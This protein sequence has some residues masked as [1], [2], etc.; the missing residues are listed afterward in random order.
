MAAGSIKY[1]QVEPYGDT[2]TN[3][4]RSRSTQAASP[5]P[6]S[7]PA[8]WCPGVLFVHG[9]GGSQEQYVARARKIAAL[10]CV[11]LTFD[12]RGHA[13]TRAAVRDRLARANLRDVLAAYDLLARPPACRPGAIAVVG[14]SYGGYLAAI[15][16]TMRP[17]RW[18]A[19]RAPALTWTPAG[20]CP[21]CSCTRT[22]TCRPTAASL[23]PV[24]ENRALQA[25]RDFKG[26]VL[27]I[28][29]EHD[30]IIPKAVLQSYREACK[31]ARSLTYRCVEGADHGL[32]RE[33][34]HRA[35][36]SMLVNWLKEMVFHARTGAVVPPS[37]DR[38]VQGEVPE[39]VEAE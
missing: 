3:P 16:T 29:S 10:G 23:V 34:D 30:K 4:S 1:A 38:T 32:T 36:T 11:C 24:E 35:Y 25:C 6:W 20:S 9:W 31:E 17:V 26:D 28:Q 13:Q 22:R 39:S 27:L 18:L 12:L 33:S 8:R 7:R 19:L 14:S 37:G 5:A 2:M 15:L 21:S